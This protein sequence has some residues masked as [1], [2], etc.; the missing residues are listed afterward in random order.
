MAFSGSTNLIK[1]L[2]S[3]PKSLIPT[4]Y[5]LD[6]LIKN[7]SLI[8]HL[9]HPIAFLNHANLAWPPAAPNRLFPANEPNEVLRA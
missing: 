7:H 4:K 6:R 1:N 3:V 9:L 5:I 8:N 2:Y